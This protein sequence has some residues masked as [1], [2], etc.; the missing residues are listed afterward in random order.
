M[1]TIGARLAT[2]VLLFCG[3]AP[4]LV[5]AQD[6][7]APD[8]EKARESLL[9]TDQAWAAAASA[10]KDAALVASFWSDDG[11]IVP[12][13]EPVISGKAAILEFVTGSFAT[14]GFHISWTPSI[15]HVHVSADGTMGYSASDSVT[16]FPGS[17]GKLATMQGRGVSIWE[18]QPGGEW[19][20]V[21]DIWNDAPK[22]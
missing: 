10:G 3:F 6:L 4:G 12:A 2:L 20:C 11:V 16:T 7:S 15:E 8:R 21:Y 5:A 18:R 17:D 9:R 14:P 19:K 1:K 22:P 13:G